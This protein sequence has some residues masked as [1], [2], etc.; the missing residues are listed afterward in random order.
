MAQTME[1]VIKSPTAQWAAPMAAEITARAKASFRPGCTK[2]SG[3]WAA[4]ASSSSMA[5]GVVMIVGH[6]AASSLR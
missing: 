2:R 1:A 4:R 6:Q 3:E 5:A